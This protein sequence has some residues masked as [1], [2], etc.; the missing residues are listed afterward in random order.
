M[1]DLKSSMCQRI[2]NA[3]KTILR[4]D[5]TGKDLFESIGSLSTTDT[6]RNDRSTGIKGG[7]AFLV[8]NGLVVNKEYRNEDFNVITDNEALAIE[9]ELS[10][11][12]NF[13]LA[14]IYCPNGNTAQMEILTFYFFNILTIYPIMS[15]LS[16]ISTRN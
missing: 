16:E 13:T 1:L 14:T 2:S 12:Q 15:C 3:A 10:N 11:N 4:V 6:I 9:L 7:V 8:K 5:I